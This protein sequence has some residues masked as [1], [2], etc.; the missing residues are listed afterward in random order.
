MVDKVKCARKGKVRNGIWMVNILKKNQLFAIIPWTGSVKYTSPAW[1]LL[2]WQITLVRNSCRCI[3]LPFICPH[4]SHLLWFRTC[5]QYK[6][7]LHTLQFVIIYQYKSTIYCWPCQFLNLCS[8]FVHN[9]QPM[10][11]SAKNLK[12]FFSIRIFDQSSVD[13]EDILTII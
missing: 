9:Q 12:T 3:S 10:E 4:M 13:Y 2:L 6:Q 7:F 11:H 8:N 5:A 1:K